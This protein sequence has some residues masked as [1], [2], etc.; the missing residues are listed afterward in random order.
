ME[1]SIANSR[2]RALQRQARQ[3]QTRELT[4]ELKQLM[5]QVF[6]FL[7]KIEEGIWDRSFAEQV[8]MG[9]ERKSSSELYDFVHEFIRRAT[10]DRVQLFSLFL[11]AFADSVPSVASE[12]IILRNALKEK[13]NER[14]LVSARIHMGIVLG[15]RLYMRSP[16]WFGGK[17][18]TFQNLH[19]LLMHI[20]QSCVDLDREI[21]VLTGGLALE[22]LTGTHLR[23]HHD[24]DVIVLSN[25]PLY[26]DT[27]EMHT[28]AYL[29][30]LGCS[31]EFLLKRCVQSIPW[32]FQ[33]ETFDV[34]VVCPEFLFCSKIFRQPSLQDWE[35]IQLLVK[36]FGRLFD[37]NLIED[38]ARQ[39]VCG[40]DRPGI[41]L[42][43]L[44][45]R[46]SESMFSQLQESFS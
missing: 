46:D 13:R 21:W 42:K 38:L 12:V 17:S 8:C 11:S 35:D 5:M 16:H 6:A 22:L 18:G 27:D 43:I 33:D 10:G 40:F 7:T 39:N 28:K 44:R 45:S 36:R 14:V 24:M 1:L 34:A 3:A 15:M 2:R 32:F 26:L 9:F 20:P 23:L 41:L 19:D 30:V 37:L 29:G 25:E 31:R 4:R